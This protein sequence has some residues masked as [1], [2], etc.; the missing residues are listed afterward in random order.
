[1]TLM[2]VSCSFSLFGNSHLVKIVHEAKE[3]LEEAKR[4]QESLALV[5][6]G[7]GND[8]LFAHKYTAATRDFQKAFALLTQ[9]KYRCPELEFLIFFGQTIAYDNLGAKDR[10]QEALSSLL[11]ALHEE[12]YNQNMEP[13]SPSEGSEEDDREAIDMLKNL[14]N[15]AIS[16]EIQEILG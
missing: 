3:S 15:L 12:K 5:F 8:N 10:C 16:P 6:I 7:S 11:I 13:T 1:M 4:H 9:I 14:A 2:I